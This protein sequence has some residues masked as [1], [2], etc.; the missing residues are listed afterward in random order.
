MLRLA[1]YNGLACQLLMDSR[2]IPAGDLPKSDEILTVDFERGGIEP[3]NDMVCNA[4]QTN[5]NGR[6]LGR[7]FPRKH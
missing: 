5:N 1:K 4:L 2:E 7:N 3:T 6:L